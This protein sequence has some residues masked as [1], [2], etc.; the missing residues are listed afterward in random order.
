MLKRLKN[1]LKRFYCLRIQK[2]DPMEYRI[3]QMRKSGIRIGEHCR[4]FTSIKSTEPYLIQIGDHV[5]VS[6]SV[7]FCTHDNGIIKVL[8]GKTDVVGPIT[9]GNNCFIGM[10]SILML[11]VTLGDNCVVGAGSVVTHSFP[12]HTVLAGN[13]AKA[14]CTTEEYAA[15]YAPYAVNAA[16]NAG[17][18]SRKAFWEHHPEL[19]VKRD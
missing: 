12:P 7:S 11:G 10:H 1:R 2:Q 16:D 5:T 14:L 6:E 4:I 8:P 18:P 13:P 15:K 3:G 17:F 9:V 19:L